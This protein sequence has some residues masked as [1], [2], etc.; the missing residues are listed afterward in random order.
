M[1]HEDKLGTGHV[2]NRAKLF[3]RKRPTNPGVNRVKR[4]SEQG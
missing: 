1:R 4:P 3:N 2:G